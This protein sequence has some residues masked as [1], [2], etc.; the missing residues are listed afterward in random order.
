MGDVIS[1]GHEFLSWPLAE[2]ACDVSGESGI[3]YARRY[4]SECCDLDLDDQME[5]SQ[6]IS[7]L[8]TLCLRSKQGKSFSASETVAWSLKKRLQALL[9]IAVATHGRTMAL[10]ATCSDSS[11]AQV[12]EL[13]ID[14]LA[15]YEPEDESA[16]TC[17]PS[18]GVVLELRLPTSADQALWLNQHFSE[19][20]EA[21]FASLATD[22]VLSINGASPESDWQVPPAWLD[23]IAQSLESHDAMMTMAVDSVCPA[24][25]GDVFIELDLEAQLL[26]VLAHEK[27]TLLQHIHRLALAYHWNE[28][29]I[30]SL[31]TNRRQYY[32]GQLEQD[33]LA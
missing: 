6:L 3:F 32:I 20:N 18:A 29:E 4:G 10:Q 28:Q 8:L 5:R 23:S 26:S 16:I 31:P 2:T 14:L 15:F 33:A 11:C 12:L 30:L 7:Q 19:N 27:I 9:A 24:C 13:A 25:G 1:N 22:L 21:L 17:Q